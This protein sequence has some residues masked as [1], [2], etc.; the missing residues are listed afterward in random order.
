MDSS[1]VQ[2]ESVFVILNTENLKRLFSSYHRN[3][4][5]SEAFF[6]MMSHIKP[7]GY[8][9]LKSSTVMSEEPTI[10][11]TVWLVSLLE[12]TPVM[13]QVVNNVP[14][15]RLK[16]ICGLKEFN[17]YITVFTKDQVKQIVHT[18]SCALQCPN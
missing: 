3:L 10:M 8:H 11:E 14:A 12:N 7:N 2:D 18:N 16:I 17:K 1:T 9:I 4:V 5:S 6:Y 13:T 15:T